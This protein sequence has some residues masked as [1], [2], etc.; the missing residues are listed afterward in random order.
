MK[1]ETII[2][3]ILIIYT[4]KNGKQPDKIFLKKEIINYYLGRKLIIDNIPLTN[5]DINLNKLDVLFI[6]KNGENY[7]NNYFPKI[8]QNLQKNISNLRFY[9]YENNSQD[10]TK[11]ILNKY[12]NFN[13]RCEKLNNNEVNIETDIQNYIKNKKFKRYSNILEARNKLLNFYKNNLLNSNNRVNLD[14]NWILLQDIDIIYNY[15]TILELSKAIK[16]KPNGVMFCANTSYIYDNNNIQ[17]KYYDILALNYG[18]FFNS[19][20]GKHDYSG[21]QN[22]FSNSNIFKLESGFGGIALIRKDVFLSTYLTYN[23]PKESKK[24]NCYQQ[25]YLC[26]HWDYC[27]NIRKFGDIYLVKEAK[28]IWIEDNIYEKKNYKSLINKFINHLKL[29]T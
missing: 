23:I 9:I 6:V 26:E 8:H 11:N 7:L 10:K 15:Q 24:Y 1:I 2:K 14:N 13:I 25:D 3:N 4:C 29:N 22:L 27:K 19:K 18:R 5:R 12:S 17:E 28:A 21:I 16:E 20:N